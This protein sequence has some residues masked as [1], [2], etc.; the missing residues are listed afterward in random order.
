[1]ETITRD[2][3][4]SAKKKYLDIIKTDVFI[5]PTEW[6]Y[7]LSCDAT[8]AELVQKVRTAKKTPL[9]PY[10]IIPPSKDWV[11]EN[12]KLNEAQKKYL[13]TLGKRVSIDDKEHIV[14]LVL[15][16]K[17]LKAI[18]P[19]VAPGLKTIG[20][21]IPSHWFSEIVREINKPLISTS[22]NSVGDNFVSKLDDL[23]QTIKSISKLAIND[24]EKK[25][26]PTIVIQPHDYKDRY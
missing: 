17:N 21:K 11:L 22:A 19:N 18:A 2:E 26:V 3:L 10:S 14:T 4:Y 25:G 12:C 13:N 24:G 7:A 1:M 6:G 16:L 5:H 8:N 23:S 20:I 9:Q 15:E